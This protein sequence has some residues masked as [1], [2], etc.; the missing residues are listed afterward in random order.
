MKT[1]FERRSIRKYKS[2][3]VSKDKI[4]KVLAAAMAAPSAGDSQPWHFIVV[5]DQERL[6]DITKYHEYA[7]MLNEAPV[8]VIVCGD[9]SNERYSHF[10]VQDCSAATQNILLAARGLGLGTVWLGVYP[11]KEYVRQTK[12]LFALPVHIEPL[13]VI[14]VGYPAEE[15]PPA[16][17]YN[18]NKVHWNQWK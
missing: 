7:N 13:A 14:A 15:K 1:I 12:R 18:E 2:D 17:R 16:D 10:W 6:R 8:G 5:D 11:V 3:P 4:K 9:T